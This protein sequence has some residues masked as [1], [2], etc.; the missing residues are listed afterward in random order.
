M[1]STHQLTRRQIRR[2]EKLPEDHEVVSNDDGPPIVCGPRGQLFR[3][4]PN[5]RLAALVET[6]QSYLHVNG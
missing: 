6:V 1:P 3:V 4:M 2:L 5:G